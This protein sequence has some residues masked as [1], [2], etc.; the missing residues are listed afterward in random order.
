MLK[1]SS[2]ENKCLNRQTSKLRAMNRH[3]ERTFTR[4][5]FIFVDILNTQ[6]SLHRQCLNYLFGTTFLRL[7]SSDSR[8]T[9]FYRVNWYFI[10]FVS[11][12]LKERT[13]LM[14]NLCFHRWLFLIKNGAFY[15]AT[16]CISRTVGCFLAFL[17]LFFRLLD[18]EARKIFGYR[19]TAHISD[20]LSHIIH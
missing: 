9:K 14:A 16:C 19:T 15:F 12:R 4:L 8:I 2:L 20:L 7:L 13:W 18:L 10:F 5:T 3:T 6:L 11:F 1:S 17:H